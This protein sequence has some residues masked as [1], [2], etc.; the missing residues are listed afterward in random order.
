VIAQAVI[1]EIAGRLL[2]LLLLLLLPRSAIASG[3]VA[4]CDLVW[5]G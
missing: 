3:G 4:L 2:L 1:R 5:T